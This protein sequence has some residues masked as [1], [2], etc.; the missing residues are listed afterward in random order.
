MRVLSTLSDSQPIHPIPSY[1][2]V[3]PFKEYFTH[4]SQRQRQR[5]VLLKYRTM[6]EADS[7]GETKEPVCP[8]VRA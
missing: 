8:R 1:H 6:S 4:Q 3:Q 2:T 5:H 7:T